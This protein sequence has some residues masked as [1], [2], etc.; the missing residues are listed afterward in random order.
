[1]KYDFGV[2]CVWLYYLLTNNFRIGFY[3]QQNYFLSLLEFDIF[4]IAR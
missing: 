4:D 1:M 2:Y 3:K